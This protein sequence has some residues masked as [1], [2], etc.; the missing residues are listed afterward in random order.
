MYDDRIE[1]TSPGKLPYGVTVDNYLNGE[2]SVPRNSIVAEVF[3]RLGIIEKLATGILRIKNEYKEFAETPSFSI[4]DN[5]IKIALPKVRYVDSLK[6]HSTGESIL[7]LLK[8]NGPMSRSSL[9]T[10]TGLGKTR[11][12]EVL[13]SLVEKGKV[14]R[15]GKSRGVKYWLKKDE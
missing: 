11:L 8:Y 2:V 14:E 12:I 13:N 3:H 10:A 15:T 4:K 6:Q 7:V 5:L 1:I 9:E